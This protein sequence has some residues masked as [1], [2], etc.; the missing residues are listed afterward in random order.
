MKRLLT[1]MLA[2]VMCFMTSV[3]S[4]SMPQVMSYSAPAGERAIPT[5]GRLVTRNDHIT[6]QQ[7]EQ[8]LATLR[9]IKDNTARGNYD[10]YYTGVTCS[11]AEEAEKVI[12]A[13]NELFLSHDDYILYNN[14]RGWRRMYVEPRR[15]NN[16]KYTFWMYGEREG[17]RGIYVVWK[18]EANA[19]ELLRQHD[20]TKKVIDSL[21]A[22]APKDLYDKV[23]Y[24]NDRVA[25][26]IT[27]DMEG[28]QTGNTKRNPYNGL[29]E[30]K[31]VCT[32][33]AESFFSLCY[34]SGISCA[35]ADCVS[36]YSINGEPDHKISMVN[37]DGRWKDVD[38]TWND[39]D[40]G[41]KYDYF[42]VD[43]DDAW[44]NHINGIAPSVGP[45]K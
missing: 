25:E 15:N 28:Y 36:K 12:R 20:E 45:G 8:I 2:V 24:Y 38:V 37:L 9:K 21:I 5:P 39:T 3:C 10:F 22:E 35:V 1:I 34:Y 40:N 33:Y 31:S 43:L 11:S 14:E 16:G 6:I 30:G 17:T 13:F 18:P 44:Q 32:G 29:I 7:S 26:R 42:M 27:Y 41:I 19:N 4:Y 23:K